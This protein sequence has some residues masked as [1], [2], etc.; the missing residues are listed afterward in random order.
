MLLTVTCNSAPG[1]AGKIQARYG[2]F[3]APYYDRAA[4]IDRRAVVVRVETVGD[5]AALQDGI[6]CP[7][8]LYGQVLTICD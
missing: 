6:G 4:M 8:E 7:L 2:R 1:D 5:F 3:L